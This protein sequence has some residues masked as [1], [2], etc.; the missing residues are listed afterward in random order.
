MKTKTTKIIS[1]VLLL[2]AMIVGF[3]TH[4]NAQ[5]Y[6]AVF[7]CEEKESAQAPEM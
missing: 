5:K 2:V 4:A 1:T 6:Y 7:T 3:N